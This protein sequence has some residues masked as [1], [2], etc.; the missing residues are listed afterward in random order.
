M[1]IQRVQNKCIRDDTKADARE[2]QSKLLLENQKKNKIRL[3]TIFNMADTIIVSPMLCIDSVCLS[4]CVCVCVCP[5][6][7]LAYRSD[8]LTTCT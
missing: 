3:K 2:W 1:S 8:S 5:S 6:H 7:F 4:V